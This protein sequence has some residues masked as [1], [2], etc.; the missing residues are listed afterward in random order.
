MSLIEFVC[1]DHPIGVLGCY[2][3][4]WGWGGGVFNRLVITAKI[5]IQIKLKV[6][7]FP[8]HLWPFLKVNVGAK[9]E[10]KLAGNV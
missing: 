9:S 4:V 2:R 5:T 3:V 7:E 10:T 1:K 8:G 6:D